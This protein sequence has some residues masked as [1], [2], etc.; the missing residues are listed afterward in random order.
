M[1]F[2]GAVKVKKNPAKMA[3]GYAVS[4]PVG[5]IKDPEQGLR[6]PQPVSDNWKSLWV[7]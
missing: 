7:S 1:K 2:L 5:L 3:V 4:W 6:R